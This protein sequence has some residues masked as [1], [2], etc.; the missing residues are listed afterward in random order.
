MFSFP[1]IETYIG[2][3]FNNCTTTY[4]NNNQYKYAAICYGFYDIH[5]EHHRLFIIS[6]IAVEDCIQIKYQITNNRIV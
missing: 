1:V 5:K 6:N 3:H 4:Y 2:V